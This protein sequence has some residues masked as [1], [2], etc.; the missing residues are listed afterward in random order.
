MMYEDAKLSKKKTVTLPIQTLTVAV[1]G[2][3]YII[4]FKTM[5]ELGFPEY[6]TH[7]CEQLYLVS[8]TYYMTP[9]GN[10]PMIPIHRGT[11]QG[12]TL[13]PFLFTFCME[14]LLM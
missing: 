12:D 10:T 9:Y 2:I 14:P 1:G 11:L 7:T 8:G 3:D 4:L 6:Y 13:S 5:R